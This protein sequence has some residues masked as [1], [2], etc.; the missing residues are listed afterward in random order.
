[1]DLANWALR[2]SPKF[3]TGVKYQFHKGFFFQIRDSE[4]PVTL[5]PL[6]YV[7]HNKYI[8]LKIIIFFKLN[9]FK[10][11]IFNFYKNYYGQNNLFI[12][13][14]ILKMIIHALKLIQKNF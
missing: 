14:S 12:V 11:Y 8:I 1:M 6:K 10:K 3:T 2:T 7:V 5:R 4:I 13:N 9:R